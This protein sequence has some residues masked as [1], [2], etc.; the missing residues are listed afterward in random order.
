M[1]QGIEN[2]CPPCVETEQPVLD[3]VNKDPFLDTPLDIEELNSAIDSM[4]V[5]SIPGLD[6]INYRVI[7]YLPQEMRKYY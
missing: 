3:N 6:G 7:Q 1:E 4:E 5:E 2:L